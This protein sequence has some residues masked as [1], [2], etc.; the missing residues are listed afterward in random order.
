MTVGFVILAHE[1][2]IQLEMLAKSLSNQGAP[3]VVHIDL[4]VSSKE[5]N[6][7]FQNIAKDNVHF[8]TRVKCEWGMFGIVKATQNAAMV[9]LKKHPEVT[10]V[11]LLSG[12]CLPA[13]PID[14]LNKF[15]DQNPD[16]DFVESI[17]LDDE[18]WVKGGLSDERFDYFFPIGWRRLPKMFDI[19]VR[20]Q[21]FMGIN[22]KPPKGMLPYIGSQWWCLT[23]ATLLK[24]LE[25]PSRPQFDRYFRWALI[26][27]ELYFQ[28]LT[29]KFAKDIDSKSLTLSVFDGQGR[30]A[31]LY[32]D[33]L[34][35]IRESDA[36]FVRKVWPRARVL[37][38]KLLNLELHVV[39]REG[40][41]ALRDRLE[42]A[43]D[44]EDHAEPGIVNMGNYKTGARRLQNVTPAPY[45]VLTGFSQVFENTTEWATNQFGLLTHGSL[46]GK[47]NVEFADNQKELPGNITANKR[48]R[49][50]KPSGFLVN[51]LLANPDRK[52][53]FL[54]DSHDQPRIRGVLAKDSNANIYAI[55]GA[56]LMALIDSKLKGDKLLVAAQR[57]SRLE[58]NL[59]RIFQGEDQTGKV[60]IYSV[61]DLI[62]APS[63]FYRQLSN[64]LSGESATGSVAGPQIRDLSKLKPLIRKLERMGM[65][66]DLGSHMTPTGKPMLVVNSDENKKEA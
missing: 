34:D 20:A 3:V 42:A 25:N 50:L 7:T 26:P 59:L 47:A 22:R 11:Y 60:K 1:N 19:L 57:H 52:H 36:F 40:Q 43:A 39:S 64:E 44:F 53:A 12:S 31:I 15:L 66:F 17:H 14:Q 63:A 21:R 13:K 32:D 33:Q 58:R 27:D 23:R 16:T 4:K 54:Y 41:N 24:I 49:N 48:I 9:L 37:Y 30:P 2:L 6:R 38:E 28:S 65:N 45:I 46:F 5:Y 18:K 29:R 35:L 61:M 8:C 51:V 56:W 55:K 62:N 10:H